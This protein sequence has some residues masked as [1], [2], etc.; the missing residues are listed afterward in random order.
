MANISLKWSVLDFNQN[1]VIHIGWKH[2]Q[3]MNN[4]ALYHPLQTWYLRKL[5]NGDFE[6]KLSQL[7]EV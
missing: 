7:Y 2:C 6:V 5:Q 1:R 4:I 3:V